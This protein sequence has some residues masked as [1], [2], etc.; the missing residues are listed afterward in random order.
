MAMSYR[1]TVDSV[2]RYSAQPFSGT[3]TAQGD[4]YIARWDG[5][6]TTSLTLAR[7][8]LVMNNEGMLFAYRKIR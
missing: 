1:M 8:T 7:D 6:G 5:A 3:W 2:T 4:R